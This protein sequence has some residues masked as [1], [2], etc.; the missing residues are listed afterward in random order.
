MKRDQREKRHVVVIDD[1]P[2]YLRFMEVLLGAEGFRVSTLSSSDALLE[3]LASSRP[4]LVITDACLP[5]HEPFS[6]LHHLRSQDAL[7]AI[8]VLVCTGAVNEVQERR[9]ELARSGI[10]VLMKPFD[11]DA[12]LSRIAALLP[13]TAAPAEAIGSGS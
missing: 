4:D 12:L 5:G 8:P 6:V 3:L 1:S 13:E 7:A 10:D 11:V 2:D 9:E